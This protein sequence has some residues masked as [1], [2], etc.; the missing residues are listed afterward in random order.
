MD[1]QEYAMSGLET[2]DQQE[3]EAA[4]EPFDQCAAPRVPC[5]HR[6]AMTTI[7]DSK[8]RAFDCFGR[9]STFPLEIP[10]GMTFG[11]EYDSHT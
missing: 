9:E 7:G 10:Q 1:A 6:W 11:E 5:P 4:E 8:G 2:R 3:A